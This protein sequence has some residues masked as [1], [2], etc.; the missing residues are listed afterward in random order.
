M[1]SSLRRGVLA[2]TIAFS[3][4]PLTACGAGFDAGTDQVN[5]NH[6]WAETDS[7]RIQNVT[8]LLSEDQDG[9]ASVIAR[10]FNNG[11]EDQTLEGI[12]V[13]D[14]GAQ[15]DL[16][17]AEGESEI[18]VPSGGWVALGGD[19]NAAAVFEDPRAAELS[20]GAAPRMVFD[21]STSGSAEMHPRVVPVTGDFA[22]NEG[23]G[24]SPAPAPD[25]EEEAAEPAEEVE[26]DP[27]EDQLED[28]DAPDD[29]AEDEDDEAGRD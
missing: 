20:L 11:D 5:P 10:I 2:A 8:V 29:E 23:W 13:A 18:V 25:P 17:P 22:Y 24:P 28:P 6:A 15:A 9:P 26:E 14:S 1:S 27:E 12:A 21:L 3:I 19:G 7:I 4:L 16:T